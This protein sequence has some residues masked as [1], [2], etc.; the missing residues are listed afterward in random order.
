MNTNQLRVFVSFSSREPNVGEFV[1]MLWAQLSNQ[2]IEVY[3]YERPWGPPYA[4]DHID[5]KC[6][7]EIEKADCFITVISQAAFTSMHVLT[8]VEHALSLSRERFIFPIFLTAIDDFPEPFRQ[9]ASIKSLHNQNL[10]VD[11][12]S[13]ISHDV[14]SKI[15]RLFCEINDIDY[16]PYIAVPRLPIQCKIYEEMTMHFGGNSEYRAGKTEFIMQEA[17]KALLYI[18]EGKLKKAKTKL[19]QISEMMEEQMNGIPANY[20]KTLA[21]ALQYEMLSM[22]LGA[23]EVKI[24]NQSKKANKFIRSLGSNVDANNYSLLG[25]FNLL[26]GRPSKAY[27]Y[28]KKASR[29]LTTPD[30]AAYYNLLVA[31]IEMKDDR[32]V[33]QLVQTLSKYRDGA[34]V[35]EPGEHF[36][37]ILVLLTARCFL[38]ELVSPLQEFEAL[39]SADNWDMNLV[40]QFLDN[41]A[42]LC[43]TKL[44]LS[45]AVSLLRVI[46]AL[47]AQL[48]KSE[49]SYTD[50]VSILQRK[51][52][53]AS[54]LGDATVSRR[55][56]DKI[57]NLPET[58]NYITILVECA[59]IL[60]S[61]EDH[62]ECAKLLADAACLW[63]PKKSSVSIS[64]AEFDYQKG[65]VAWMMSKNE[66]AL[67]CYERSNDGD[68]FAW[69]GD[70][71]GWVDRTK[72]ANFS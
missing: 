43:K 28:F 5:D 55:S 70:L 24:K 4:G 66:I 52:H 16:L 72:L 19:L 51:A 44:D 8:E 21:F 6:R 18:N 54:E 11:D 35:S 71:Y 68:S 64:Q 65:L 38:G 49:S 59:I 1:R 67:D 50:K 13:V 17:E 37:V 46:E 12:G 40:R 7:A 45:S 30:A 61:V 42:A 15:T 27:K 58:K 39:G 60:Y 63:S 48:N 47:E 3:R 31:A 10:S 62:K 9:L 25:N 33:L 56:I 34:L 29:H 22:D 2:P 57:L 20:P 53:L 14:I 41:S 36:K 69:Y 23:N 32:R 26:E